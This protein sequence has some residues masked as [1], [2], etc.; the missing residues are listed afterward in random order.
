MERHYEAWWVEE[1]AALI[2]CLQSLLV[3]ISTLLVEWIMAHKILQAANKKL[4]ETQIAL[5]YL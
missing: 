5:M 1:L 3:L 2:K 4:Q